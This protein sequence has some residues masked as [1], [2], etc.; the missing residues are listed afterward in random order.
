MKK[1]TVYIIT[2]KPQGVLYIGSTTRLKIR[3]GQHKRKTHPKTFSAKFNLNKLVYFEY[4]PNKEAMLKRERQMKKW[5][6]DWKIRLIEE[7][8]PSWDDLYDKV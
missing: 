4:L 2:N 6:R 3:I 1:Y 5:K 7:L 8:N